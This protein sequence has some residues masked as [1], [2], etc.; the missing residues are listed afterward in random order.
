MSSQTFL[1]QVHSELGPP[2]IPLLTE[3]QSTYEIRLSLHGQ[4][5]LTETLEIKSWNIKNK[6]N[7]KSVTCCM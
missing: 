3:H 5:S 7:R 2:D 1:S 4:A 6:N